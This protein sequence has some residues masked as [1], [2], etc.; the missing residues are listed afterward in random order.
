LPQISAPRRLAG[1]RP[2]GERCAAATNLVRREPRPPA[3]PC[4]GVRIALAA[5]AL[6]VSV[7]SAQP[8]SAASPLTGETTLTR[9]Y[10]Q[11]LNAQFAE[12]ARTASACEDA[13]PEACAVLDATRAWW[14]IQ[15]DPYDRRGDAEFVRKADEVI[16]A[17]EAWA[18]REPRNAEAWFYTGGAYGVRVQWRVLRGER[19]AA[20]RDG[21]QIKEA[22]ETALRLA[23]DLEDANF[24]IGLYQY[25]ADVAPTAARMLRWLLMLPGGNRREGLARMQR[26]HDKGTLLR[27]EA[28]Y[29]LHIVYLWYEKQFDQALDLVEDLAARYPGNPLFQQIIAE[30]HDTYFHDPTASARAYERLLRLARQRRLNEAAL[31]EAQGHL[32]LAR[33]L[34]R[35]YESDRALQHARAALAASALPYAGEAQAW[36]AAGRALLHLGQTADARDAFDRADAA[37][38]ADDPYKL[39]EQ[40]RAARRVTV[41]ATTAEAYRHSL[42]GLRAFER[43]A[44]DTAEE[45]FLRALALR[46]EDA[47][48]R[49]RYGRLLNARGATA[50]AREQFERVAGAG[51]TAPPI[52]FAEACLA[53]AVRLENDGDRARALTLYERAARTFGAFNDTRAL[54][55][56]NAARLR[57]AL[58]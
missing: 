8:S 54:A 42:D 28:D 44:F 47:V 10:D 50:R 36:L 24:G 43:K 17:A 22:L 19:L 1:A 53:L 13:P 46:P 51:A 11:I 41:D 56:R 15:L 2:R 55:S 4:R 35:L 16:A 33:Q 38:P 58:R 5:A 52:V 57:N 40:L 3:R 14:R 23:P 26:T 49:Y 6:A 20:A 48:T 37:M 9:V 34:E 7:L 45:R 39:R 21:K 25:Y 27:G 31:A 30:V 29:Q 12:A 18:R 32:G